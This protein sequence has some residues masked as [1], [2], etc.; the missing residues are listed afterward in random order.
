MLKLMHD[1]QIGVDK[2]GPLFYWCPSSVLR[3]SHTIDKDEQLST[4]CHPVYKHDREVKLKPGE[5]RTLDIAIKPVG[6]HWEKGDE[7]QF[8]ISGKEIIPFPIL[9]VPLPL[10]NNAGKH[11]VHC[12]GMAAEISYLLVPYI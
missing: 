7:L 4:D 3:A 8:T 9:G 2:T 1:H 10:A 11:V 12:G 5:K 6:L